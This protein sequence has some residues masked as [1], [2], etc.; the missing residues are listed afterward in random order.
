MRPARLPS[1]AD[2]NSGQVHQEAWVTI[3][4]PQCHPSTCKLCCSLMRCSAAS[5]LSIL[6]SMSSSRIGTV[7]MHSRRTVNCYLISGAQQGLGRRPKRQRK[8]PLSTLANASACSAVQGPLLSLPW[9]QPAHGLLCS[10]ADTLRQLLDGGSR[11][12]CDRPDHQLSRLDTLGEAHPAACPD[13]RDLKVAR[14]LCMRHL[15]LQLLLDVLLRRTC[16]QLGGDASRGV[17]L[18]E[19]RATKVGRCRVTFATALGC[20]AAGSST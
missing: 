3:K 17:F 9:Q 1:L 14:P 7:H 12:G 19:P 18:E 5:L 8:P 11:V 16:R 6:S 2:T 13:R 20:R 15:F 10:S 4:R